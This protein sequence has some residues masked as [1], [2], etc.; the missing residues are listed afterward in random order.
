MRWRSR[1]SVKL[2]QIVNYSKY[3]HTSAL[4]LCFYCSNSIIRLLFLLILCTFYYYLLFFLWNELET[5]IVY[6]FR[7]FQFLLSDNAFNCLPVSFPFLSFIYRTRWVNLYVFYDFSLI[8]ASIQRN[9]VVAI[10]VESFSIIYFVCLIVSVVIENR[11]SHLTTT[12]FENDYNN[13]G[14]PFATYTLM[15]PTSYDFW[16]HSSTL[17]VN[18]GNTCENTSTFIT[19]L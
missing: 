12:E 4:I 10:P 11:S 3:T 7:R 18:I 1:K 8:V 17:Q 19:H 6:L 2:K 15:F 5:E 9:A 16:K 14:L 13:N